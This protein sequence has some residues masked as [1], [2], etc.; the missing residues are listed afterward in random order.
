[1]SKKD[2]KQNIQETQEKAPKEGLI[3]KLRNWFRR[4]HWIADE[5]SLLKDGIRYVI[6]GLGC[7]LPIK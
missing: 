6:Y 4:S 2:K 3:Q 7:L 5:E 1:M